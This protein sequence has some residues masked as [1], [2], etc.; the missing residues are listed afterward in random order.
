[1]DMCHAMASLLDAAGETPENPVMQVLSVNPGV[2]V[3]AATWPYV[4]FKGGSEPG[5]LGLTWLLRRQDGRHFVVSMTWNDTQEL[6]ETEALIY[7]GGRAI[8]LLSGEP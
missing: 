3:D 6:L 2:A 7:L 1:M 4:G 8:D 5:V